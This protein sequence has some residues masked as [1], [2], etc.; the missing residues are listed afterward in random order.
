M[1]ASHRFLMSK[2]NGAARQI[3]MGMM[4]KV[5]RKCAAS[6]IAADA[7]K[8]IRNFIFVPFFQLDVGFLLWNL[9]D[10]DVYRIN[11]HF[12]YSIAL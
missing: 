2:R 6:K 1:N 12:Y 8:V 10:L 7:S 4:E 11:T 5:R 3:N 9:H